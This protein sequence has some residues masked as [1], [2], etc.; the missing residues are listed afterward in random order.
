MLNL[1]IKNKI[2]LLILFLLFISG[3]TNSNFVD[4]NFTNENLTNENLIDEN[5]E[6]ANSENTNLNN[7]SQANASQSNTSQNNAANNDVFPNNSQ[8]NYTIDDYNNVETIVNDSNFSTLNNE[9][10][11]KY[12]FIFS[13][14]KLKVKR[15]FENIVLSE[16]FVPENAENIKLFINDKETKYELGSE[17]FLQKKFS[18]NLLI[19]TF[20]QIPINYSDYEKSDK[21]LLEYD[22][23][24]NNQSTNSNQK[25]CEKYTCILSLPIIKYEDVNT[26]VK[27]V[28]ESIN[29]L[30]SFDRQLKNSEDFVLISGTKKNILHECIFNYSED[31]LKQV[32]D[33]N[34]TI[35]KICKLLPKIEKITGIKY[36]GNYALIFNRDKTAAGIYWGTKI[37]TLHNDLD[38][39]QSGLN[40]IIEQ[41]FLHELTHANIGSLNDYLFDE[42]NG[43][44]LIE[45]IA[46][47]SSNTALGKTW[48]EYRAYEDIQQGIPQLTINQYGEVINPTAVEHAYIY[49]STI[50]Y[51]IENKYGQGTIAKLLKLKQENLDMPLIN[52]FRVVTK[53]PKLELNEILFYK[54]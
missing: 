4:G 54:K 1:I 39:F 9:M 8:P 12:E 27:V 21:I 28:P 18:S 10:L 35:Q 41:V 29:L 13:P 42:N 26:Y 40:N 48:S 7:A 23:P 11:M 50:I 31:N 52:A 16:D 36:D 37:F 46:E 15:E 22:L 45:G 14:T 34:S 44:W 17:K 43:N 38:Q 49:S 33:Y 51:N 53:N 25:N 2:M 6:I 47:Y 20:Y 3:C 5:L 19:E 24:I 32:R 30:Y